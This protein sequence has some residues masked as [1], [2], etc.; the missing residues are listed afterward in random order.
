M[1]W[2]LDPYNKI[3][4]PV[5]FLKNRGLRPSLQELL[6]QIFVL[7]NVLSY[8]TRR[9]IILGIIKEKVNFAWIY[10]LG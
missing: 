2:R 10:S 4:F 3:E 1:G 7:Y 8:F 9:A 5:P 6:P